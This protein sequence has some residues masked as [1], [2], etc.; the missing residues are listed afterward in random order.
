VSPQGILPQQADILD[1]SLPLWEH[2]LLVD[3]HTLNIDA[4]S[5]RQIRESTGDNEEKVAETIRSVV[6]RRGK[7]HNPVTGSGGM[8]IGTL[9]AQGP[10]YRGP[11][12]AALGDRVA[13]LV[14]LTLTPLRLRAIKKV[15]LHSD[16]VDVEGEAILFESG[17]GARLDGTLPERLALAVLDVA[18]AP[19]QMERLVRPH[20]TVGVLGTGKSGILCLAQARRSLKGTGKLIALDASPAGLEAAQ[21]LGFADETAIVDARDPLG[22]HRTVDQLTRGLFCD[23]VVNTVNV[24]GTEMATVLAAREG[25]RAYFFNMA[26]NFQAVAL[27]AEGLGR[28]VECLIGVG[29]APGHADT[30]LNLVKTE[31]GLRAYLEERFG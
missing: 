11:I 31:P 19:A 4:A 20:M 13:T 27:G 29:Y 16:Q 22:V 6:E 2:E 5:F 28:D 3:V 24:T 23:L 8:L 12:R 15:H 9:K 17:I 14:S 10:A 7:M 30:A 18:G 21:R 25:G 1:T 26:N